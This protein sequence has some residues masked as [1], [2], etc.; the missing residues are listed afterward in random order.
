MDN[1]EHT[2]DDEFEVPCKCT[3]ENLLN[4]V[5]YLT[6]PVNE[7]PVVPAHNSNVRAT[8]IELPENSYSIKI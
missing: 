8:E 4:I 2:N 3:E 5:Q 6:E 7:S 1:I